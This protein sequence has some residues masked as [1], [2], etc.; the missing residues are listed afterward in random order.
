MFKGVP[1][2]DVKNATLGKKSDFRFNSNEHQLLRLDARGLIAIENASELLKQKV[3][4]KPG[5][6]EKALQR[7]CDESDYDVKSFGTITVAYNDIQTFRNKRL[8]FN[9]NVRYYVGLL[10]I[11]LGENYGGHYCACVYDNATQRVILY[12]SM[13]VGN[14]SEHSLNFKRIASSLF[15]VHM[16]K[17]K[18]HTCKRG[19]RYSSQPTGGF[20]SSGANVVA[21]QDPDSQHHFCY[22]EALLFIAQHFLDLDIVYTNRKRPGLEGLRLCVIKRFIW[23]L[24]HLLG[25]SDTLSEGVY[26]YLKQNF[27]Y[28]WYNEQL[29]Y[30]VVKR[31]YALN[32]SSKWAM[33]LVPHIDKTARTKTLRDLVVLSLMQSN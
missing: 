20:I 6:I 3:L 19:I 24:V 28:I 18:T 31:R 4:H 12:D 17:V 16:A 33:T 25:Y 23:G 29:R 21:I 8:K 32:R 22:M 26:S 10:A 14:A 2:I 11:D 5:F 15:D 9:N 27:R 13:Q 30:N 1:V 7:I